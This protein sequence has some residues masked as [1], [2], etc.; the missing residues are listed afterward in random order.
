MVDISCPSGNPYTIKA[1]DTL[2]AIAK[3]AGIS[4]ERLIAANPG[5]NPN[6]LQIGQVICVPGKAG[7]TCPGFMYTIAAGDTL[8]SLAQ[9]YHTTVQAIEFFNRGIDPNKLQIGQVICI[10]V[11]ACPGGTFPYIIKSGDTYYSIA[12]RYNIGVQDLLN[13]NPGVNPD[14]LYIGQTICVPLSP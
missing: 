9:R 11:G 14:K 6:R 12:R 2:Y 10:P 7:E 8:F 13:S 3:Q 4:L 1:G 5:I